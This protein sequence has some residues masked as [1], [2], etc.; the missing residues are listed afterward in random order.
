[1]LPPCAEPRS[2]SLLAFTEHNFG[3]APLNENDASAYD[4]KN[5]FDFSQA[6]L[7]PVPMPQPKLSPRAE[8]TKHP[9]EDPDGT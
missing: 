4:Y 3:P 2:I 7:A 9:V 1:M 5:A 6:P 8:V